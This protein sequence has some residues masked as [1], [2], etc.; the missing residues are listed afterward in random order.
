MSTTNSIKFI[1]SGK[2]KGKIL[3]NGVRYIGYLIG[4]LPKKF[5]FIYDADEEKDGITQ[6]F[7]RGG[8]TYIIED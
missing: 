7:N 1:K 4:S 2:H 8:L 6:W 5:A 3:L